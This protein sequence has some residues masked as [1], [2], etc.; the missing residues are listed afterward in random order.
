MNAIAVLVLG[1]TL[2]GAPA[3]VNQF[4]VRAEIQSLYDEIS[5]ATLQFVTPQD[6]DQFHAVLFTSDWSLVDAKGQKRSWADVRGDAIKTL[7]EPPYD[8]ILQSI[9]KLTLNHD[10]TEAVALVRV[11]TSRVDGRTVVEDSSIYRDTWTKTDDGW[12]VKQRE[13]IAR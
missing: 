7:P 6:V 13:Q 8:S 4:Q 1:A 5:Q 12:K 3:S 11:K 9:Q 2:A 10:G